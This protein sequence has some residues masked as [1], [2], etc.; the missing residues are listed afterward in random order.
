MDRTCPKCHADLRFKRLR[1]SQIEYPRH[2]GYK[3]ILAH[4]VKCNSP[5]VP[6]DNPSELWAGLSLFI[7]L[8]ALVWVFLS[9]DRKPAVLTGLL[10]LL[11]Y[12]LGMARFYGS[13]LKNEKRWKLFVRAED[14][15][16]S[17]DDKLRERN[18]PASITRPTRSR[19]FNVREYLKNMVFPIFFLLPL[20]VVIGMRISLSVTGLALVGIVYFFINCASQ[21]I[22]SHFEMGHFWEV[23]ILVYFFVFS[24]LISSAI[25]PWIFNTPF[26]L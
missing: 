14:H 15:W 3:L 24:L 20:I 1:T 9:L 17:I 25:H 6:K 21:L 10:L 8:S 12:G 19:T 26:L 4:C 5:L 13:H 22:H 16:M 2:S 11:L 23:L 7:F 18:S